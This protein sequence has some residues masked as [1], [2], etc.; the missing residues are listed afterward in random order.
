MIPIE[1]YEQ[2]LETIAQNE[3]MLVFSKTPNCSVCHADLPRVDEIATD[4]GLDAYLVD[5]SEH[6]LALGQLNLFSAPTVILFHEGREIH[7][8]ARF[9]D[10]LTLR[11]RIEQVIEHK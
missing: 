1:S 2:L 5:V 4:Y 8:Q 6:P 10:F 7:R 11:Y 9:I 3:L